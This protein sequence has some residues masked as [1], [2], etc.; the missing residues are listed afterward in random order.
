MATNFKN[1]W[2]I[3]SVVFAALMMTA[4]V[5]AQTDQGMKGDVTGEM[6]L[7]AG[8]ERMISAEHLILSSLESQG[9]MKDPAIAEGNS[10]LTSGERMILEGKK[11]MQNPATRIQGK[12]EMMRGSSKMMEG[13]DFIMKELKRKGLMKTTP[14][15]GDEK[16]LADGEN[17]M[18]NGKSLMM[19]G[20]RNFV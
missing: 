6:R 18:F 5:Y 2:K 8:A 1:T 20:E 11:M 12:E 16:L 15:K 10:M 3:M 9:L 7:K 13:K 19:D 4:V 17:M 14:L